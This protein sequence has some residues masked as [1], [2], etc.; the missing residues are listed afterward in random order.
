MFYCMCLFECLIHLEVNELLTL[1]MPFC[2]ARLNHICKLAFLCRNQI[3]QK[4]IKVNTEVNSR[5]RLFIYNV[6]CYMLELHEEE[7]QS[8]IVIV[9]FLYILFKCFEHCCKN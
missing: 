9:I 7:I 6:V 1:I 8:F 4:E 3:I 2:S 5:L